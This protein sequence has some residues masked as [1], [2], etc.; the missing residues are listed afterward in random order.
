MADSV[1]RYPAEWYEV[2]QQSA[3]V[4]TA[5][6][7]AEAGKS[8]FVTGVLASYATAADI[9]TVEIRDGSTVMARLNVHEMASIQLATPLVGTPGNA[10]SAVLA[11]GTANGDV[12][13]IGYSRE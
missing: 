9:G 2:A 5:T 11:A 1:K 4:A 12:T 7:A 6:R 10:V 13:L 8:H 3:G